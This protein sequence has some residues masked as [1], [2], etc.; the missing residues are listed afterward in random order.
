MRKTVLI[1]LA[2]LFLGITAN[3]QTWQENISHHGYSGSSLKTP[4]NITVIAAKG[5]EGNCEAIFIKIR[6]P[7]HWGD[8]GTGFVNVFAEN[9][10]TGEKNSQSSHF[11]YHNG[12]LY[13]VEYLN[14]W[15]S[16][17]TRRGNY[18]CNT[19]TITI[20]EKN[21]HGGKPGNKI[22]VNTHL[23]KLNTAR[24]TLNKVSF[25]TYW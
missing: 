16:G 17:N 8:I 14:A 4:D 18:P 22:V 24:M 13:F 10:T 25:E 12:W 9:P 2:T 3:A 15:C 11:H 23:D 20:Y 19:Y 7:F 6:V 21:D 5:M 1:T